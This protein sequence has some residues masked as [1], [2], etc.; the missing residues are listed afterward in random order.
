MN[1]QPVMLFLRLLH[2]VAG[3][4]WVGGAAV[5]V[6]FVLPAART[7]K[8]LD[9][10]R[11]LIWKH[12]LPRYLNVTLVLA[13]LSGLVMYSNLVVLTHGAWAWTHVGLALGVG[14]GLAII[15]ATVATFVAAPAIHRALQLDSESAAVTE[16][17][18]PARRVALDQALAR[19]AAAMRLV[20]AL[21][22]GT[23]A[24]MAMARYL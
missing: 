5:L 8:N 22:L 9:Y 18:G 1:T 10:L 2:V 3:V 6:G 17:R 23:A 16:A 12:N 24:L 15:A 11:Q 14:G 20:V 4:L 21:L 13:L 19:Y 7:Q